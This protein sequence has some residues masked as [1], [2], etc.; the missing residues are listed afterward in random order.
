MKKIVGL[1]FL[2]TLLAGCSASETQTS[3]AEELQTSTVQSSIQESSSTWSTDS[4]TTETG[5]TETT[6]EEEII[7]E[8]EGNEATMLTITVGSRTFHATLYDNE[9][10]ETLKNL[11]PLTLNMDELN[12]NEKYYYLPQSLPTS[13]ERVGNIRNGDLMLYGRDCLVLFYQNFSSSY[14]YTR[15]A[16]ID[17]PNG[18]ANELGRGSVE[19]RFELAD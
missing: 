6:D 1:T 5:T 13:S 17:D 18:F 10:V 4:T 7:N 14:S 3:T 11:L 19:V 8:S 15:I 12:G 2:L 16:T 9:T